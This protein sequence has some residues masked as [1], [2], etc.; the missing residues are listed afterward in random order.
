MKELVLSVGL[1][2]ERNVLRCLGYTRNSQPP[3]DEVVEKIREYGRV[4]E[5][6]G[7]LRGAYVSFPVM[8]IDEQ[9]IETEK[10]KILSGKLARIASNAQKIA[11]GLVSAG[12]G[13]N[14]WMEAG[15]SLL[16]VCIRDAIGT[17]MIEDGVDLLLAEIGSD[18]GLKTS[19]PFSPGYCDWDLKGQ[20]L[21]FSYFSPAPVGIKLHRDSLAMTPQKSVSF[22]TC[23]GTEM[24]IGNPCRHCSLEACFM[25]RPA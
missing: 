10:G 20:E 6:M 1:P 12:E 9:G 2:D 5:S 17:V 13:F 22:V 4:A 18:T 3:H 21:I 11:F 23:L 14:L 16:D 7:G 24:K 25:R 8:G 15:D 19:L